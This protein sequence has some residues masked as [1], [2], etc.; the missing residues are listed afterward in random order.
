[1]P[2]QM[3]PLEKTRSALLALRKTAYNYDSKTKDL[4][5]TEVA[6]HVFDHGDGVLKV[7]AEDGNG[8]ADYYGEFTGGYPTIYEKLEQFAKERGLFWEWQN[9][10]VIA[11]Y[12]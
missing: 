8:W 5:E 3:Y 9:P 1:M 7:S 4:V 2:K 10:A 11:L 12:K 6:P